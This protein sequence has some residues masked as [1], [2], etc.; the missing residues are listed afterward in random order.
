MSH[1]GSIRRRARLIG[2]VVLLRFCEGTPTLSLFEKLSKRITP[3]VFQSL[4]YTTW[5]DGA[6]S[7]RIDPSITRQETH[8]CVQVFNAHLTSQSVNVSLLALA[9]QWL[10]VL[11]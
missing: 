6:V 10:I 11:L 2:R 3:Y 5:P 7:P 9:S 8:E 4:R 1:S